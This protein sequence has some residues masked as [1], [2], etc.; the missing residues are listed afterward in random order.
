MLCVYNFN[1]WLERHSCVPISIFFAE[2]HVHSQILKRTCK[3]LFRLWRQFFSRVFP[4]EIETATE[5]NFKL[6]GRKSVLRC[7][8]SWWIRWFSSRTFEYLRCT[9]HTIGKFFGCSHDTFRSHMPSEIDNLPRQLNT[10]NIFDC[11][12]YCANHTIVSCV[13][14][15][16]WCDA[17]NIRAPEREKRHTYKTRPGQVVNNRNI[18]NL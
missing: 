7:H 8:C 11:C 1:S 9:V 12:C 3:C 10:K 6:S 5:K 16:S 2:I 4:I 18:E 13:T 15:S 17:N 14:K